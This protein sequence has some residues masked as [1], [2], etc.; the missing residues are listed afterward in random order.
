MDQNN[1]NRN[2]K[3]AVRAA[4]NQNRPPRER[5]QGRGAPG[6]DYR[7]RQEA[8]RRKRAKSMMKRRRKRLRL[9]AL[10]VAVV[11][12]AVGLVLAVTVLFK[13]ASFRVENTDKRDPVDLGPY[14]EEQILQALAVNVG[15]NIF[16]FSAK[17]RQ[18]LLE[19]ALPEL[20]TVQV[21]RSLPSTVVVQV[22]P[23]TAA[24]KVAYG[25]QW[26]VLSTSCKVMRLE[27][28]EPEGLVELQGI[29]AAQAEPGSR[30]QLSQPA[31]AEGAESTLQESA[32]GASQDGS[33]ASATPEPETAETTADEA[34]S[35]LLD[36]LEQNGL[37]D[38]LTAVQLGDLEEFSFTY[39]GRLK[40]RLGT[41][42][43]LD[44]KLRLTARVVLG[45]DGLAP[46][47]RGTLDVSSMTKAGTI[48]PVFS[49]GEP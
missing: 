16:G 36:G 31:P 9:L 35:Q 12:A 10:F 13:V 14:T 44:Y 34:L 15:D 48:N 26:A 29:E 32:A 2:R 38:G 7:Q 39:Q 41:S 25:D 4:A 23:A 19:R 11:L 30:I 17:D 33:A 3:G 27:E 45:A 49:P 22:E 6:A 24:Y 18:I 28:E 40:I 1:R 43:N 46:T 47:D 8:L 21:R 5:G 37:L 20:E 42:N